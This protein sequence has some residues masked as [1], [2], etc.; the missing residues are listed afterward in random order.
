MQE[1]DAMRAR[2]PTCWHDK[3]REKTKTEFI[4]RKDDWG[5]L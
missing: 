5:H 4:I 1:Q 2:E 3:I